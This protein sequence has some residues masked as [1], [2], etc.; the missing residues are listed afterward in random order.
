MVIKTAKNIYKSLTR[1]WLYTLVSSACMCQVLIQTCKHYGYPYRYVHVLWNMFMIWNPCSEIY[2]FSSQVIPGLVQK[3]KT[4]YIF[5]TVHYWNLFSA[6]WIL[7]TPSHTHHL[8]FSFPS[9]LRTQSI[10]SPPCLT[11]ILYTFVTSSHVICALAI[12]SSFT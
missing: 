8:N 5:K 12:V 2:S 3:P 7:S 6:R 1:Q 11:N 9:C 4:H 10:R